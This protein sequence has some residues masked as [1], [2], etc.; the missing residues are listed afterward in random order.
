MILRSL[1]AH[2]LSL[3]IK[4]PWFPLDNVTLHPMS[5][6][7]RF[8]R[9]SSSR[10]ESSNSSKRLFPFDFDCPTGSCKQASASGGSVV[11][12]CC[13]ERSGASGDCG[14]ST[15]E[16]LGGF[17]AVVVVVLDVVDAVESSL[18]DGGRGEFAE[19]ASMGCD[20]CELSG[21]TLAVGSGISD[22]VV[23]PFRDLSGG[24]HPDSYVAT[25]SPR[26]VFPWAPQRES[27]GGN[28]SG[29]GESG[30]SV[31]GGPMP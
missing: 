26:S 28:S 3:S 19:E 27:G 12:R 5:R 18:G 8:I 6:L 24:L 13:L 14:I 11:F 2:D 7:I 21:L 17:G 20:I 16:S 15:S 4:F 23:R 22:A 25:V 31:T 29:R 1:S 10:S 30:T 9:N